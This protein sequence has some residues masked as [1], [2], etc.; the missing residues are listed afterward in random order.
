MNQIKFFSLAVNEPKKIIAA[1]LFALAFFAFLWEITSSVSSMKHIENV[2]TSIKI[3]PQQEPLRSNSA[4]FTASL[5][6]DYVPVH[7]T[8]AE[9]KQSTLDLEVVGV[10]FSD[11]K[12]ESQVVIR[13]D[14]GEEKYFFVGDELP[15]G[16]VIKRITKTGVLV[17]HN[18][19]LERLSLPKNE[20]I[21]DP[22]AK[23]LIEE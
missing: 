4:V 21:F 20:L 6:G 19:A 1:I 13:V 23:P 10:M 17:L 9:I 16:A 8:D 5:F 14:E 2:E 7:L 11:N 3:A 18:G 22:P 12:D 15:G